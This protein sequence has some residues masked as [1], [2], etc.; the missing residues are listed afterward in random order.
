MTVLASYATA[1]SET[2][3]DIDGVQH[4]LFVEDSIIIS[5]SR[6]ADANNEA[7][8]VKPTAP[9]GSIVLCDI[10]LDRTT[11]VGSLG[12]RPVAAAVVPR[13]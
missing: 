10:L 3:S 2:V 13:R 1:G 12:R 11:A 7:A 8:A 6:G 9:T 4:T 5:L